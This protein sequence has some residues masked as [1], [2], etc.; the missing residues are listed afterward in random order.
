MHHM[1]LTRACRAH[2]ASCCATTARIDT[3][4]SP[5]GRDVILGGEGGT[6]HATNQDARGKREGISVL[7]LDFKAA[8]KRV[9][10]VEQ[11]V[12]PDGRRLVLLVTPDALHLAV[13]GP[14]LQ[15]VFSRWLCVCVCVCVCVCACAVCVGL[16]VGGGRLASV[17]SHW[18]LRRPLVTCLTHAPA[19]RAAV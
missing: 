14:G 16:A 7:L 15:A 18:L 19:T 1:L 11:E 6:L 4:C 12:L 8:A 10:S 17:P 9:C 3:P 13:G 2:G 5:R